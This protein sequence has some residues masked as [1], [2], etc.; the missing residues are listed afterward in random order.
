MIGDF[1]EVRFDLYCPSCKHE[2]TAESEDPCC[3]CLAIP[4]RVDSHCPEKYDKGF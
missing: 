2:D 4:A 1:K 3:E